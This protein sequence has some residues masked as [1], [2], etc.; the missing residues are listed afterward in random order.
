M[1]I[2]CS[3]CK[4]LIGEKEP[5]DD[6]STTHAKCPDC[7]KKQKDQEAQSEKQ[8]QDKSK[9]VTFKNG[10]QGILTV[11]GKESAEL[12]FFELEVNRKGFFCHES[13]R[14]E[15][16]DYI[17]GIAADEVGVTFLHSIEVP[18]EPVKKGKRKKEETERLDRPRP[19]SINYNCTIRVSKEGVCSMFEDMADRSEKFADLVVDAAMEKVKRDRQAG[20]IHAG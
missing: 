8:T 2:I 18:L 7:L 11:A 17:D 3:W 15:F 6:P 13:T 10:T 19:K 1:K 12:S 9:I 16:K 14:Q 4:K 20:G 5:F